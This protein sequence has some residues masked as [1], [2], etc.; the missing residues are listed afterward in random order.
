M[1][2]IVFCIFLISLNLFA[3]EAQIIVSYKS[4]EPLLGNGRYLTLS[5]ISLGT[6]ENTIGY[7]STVEILGK[8]LQIKKI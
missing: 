7:F 4:N 2:K 1:K 8:N 6:Y 3:K 5:E